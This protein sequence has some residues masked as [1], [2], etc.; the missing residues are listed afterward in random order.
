MTLRLKKPF[1]LSNVI[2]SPRPAQRPR[3]A[4]NNFERIRSGMGTDILLKIAI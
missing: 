3:L 1:K 2:Y 4:A